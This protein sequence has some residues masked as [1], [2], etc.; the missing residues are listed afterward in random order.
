MKDRNI[1]IIQ[2]IIQ[3]ADEIQGTIIR[4]DL[5]NYK[6]K[7]DYVVKNAICM[8]V[9]QIGEL[10]VNLS[11]DFKLKHPQMPWRDIISV[12]NRTAHTYFSID[13]EILWGIATIDIPALQAYCKKILEQKEYKS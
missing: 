3:Y 8:C 7:S 11:D 1:T 12:R 10:V 4:F 9:L 5:D 2:R 6:F 13:L